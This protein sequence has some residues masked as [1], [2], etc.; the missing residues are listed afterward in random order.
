MDA[1][2]ASIG[3]GTIVEAN[4]TIGFRYHPDCGPARIASRWAAFLPGQSHARSNPARSTIPSSIFSRR[5]IRALA[6]E[7]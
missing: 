7:S 2:N 4:V 6:N 5:R 3:E 1:D